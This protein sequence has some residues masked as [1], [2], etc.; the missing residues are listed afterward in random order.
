MKNTLKYTLITTALLVSIISSYYIGVI[1][2]LNLETYLKLE[3]ILHTLNEL[4][5]E[6]I[7]EVKKSLNSSMDLTIVQVE[8]ASKYWLMPIGEDDISSTYARISR[9]R[10]YGGFKYTPDPFWLKTHERANNII[11][12]K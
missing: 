1:R 12:A 11:Y 7:E 2:G 6:K 8:E 10:K 5:K 3:L 4:E 9:Y